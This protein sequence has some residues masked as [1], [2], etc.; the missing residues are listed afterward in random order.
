MVAD[1]GWTWSGRRGASPGVGRLPGLMGAA[2]SGRRG[3]SPLPPRTSRLTRRR[4]ARRVRSVDC[5]TVAAVAILRWA[6]ESEGADGR[7]DDSPRP[8]PQD[9]RGPP[10]PPAPVPLEAGRPARPA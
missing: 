5:R 8:L 1:A 3:A 9:D 2:G 6:A 4:R 10:A 7:A